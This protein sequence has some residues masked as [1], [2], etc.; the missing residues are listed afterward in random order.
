M[1]AHCHSSVE[2]CCGDCEDAHRLKSDNIEGTIGRDAMSQET[3][4]APE[5]LFEESAAPDDVYFFFVDDSE[6]SSEFDPCEKTVAFGGL[7]VP[8]SQLPK[9]T[10][11]LDQIYEFYGAPADATTESE[12]KWSPG[13][14]N[15]FR[16]KVNNRNKVVLAVLRAADECDVS[17]QVTAADTGL[18]GFWDVGRIREEVAKY[19]FERF[20]MKLSEKEAAGVVVSDQSGNRDSELE[21]LND[22]YELVDDGTDYVEGEELIMNAVTTPSRYSRP[23][24]VADVVVSP[25]TSMVSGDNNEYAE[26]VFER[27]VELMMEG[28]GGVAGTGLKLVPKE[29]R[30]MYRWML[31]VEMYWRP[32]RAFLELPCTRYP[33]SENPFD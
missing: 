13:H 23:L 4:S 11:L 28:S 18:C 7:M 30:N 27:I 21:F 29:F 14:G 25:T 22:F 9:F 20:V 1:L 16:E 8:G 17:V 32:S 3:P 19:S 2:D 33:L 15:Y 31:G 10:R 12:L 5:A 26:R 24:Q 6:R